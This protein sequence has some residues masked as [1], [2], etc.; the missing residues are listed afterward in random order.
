MK[1][2]T[3][4]ITPTWESIMPVLIMVLQ[5]SKA[6]PSSRKEAESELMRLARM[7]DNLNSNRKQ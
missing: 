4:D 2:E 5:N 3:I 7:V 6:Q 1:A